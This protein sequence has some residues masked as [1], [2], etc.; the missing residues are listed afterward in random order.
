[1]QPQQAHCLASSL[2][3]AKSAKNSLVQLLCMAQPAGAAGMGMGAQDDDSWLRA[4]AALLGASGGSAACMSGSACA[5]A[6]QHQRV[7][8]SHA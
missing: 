2:R 6:L 3:A 1:M 5:W 8:E 7:A 4:G